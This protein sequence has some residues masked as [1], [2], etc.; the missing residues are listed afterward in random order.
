M[1]NSQQPLRVLFVCTGNICRSPM[2]EALFRNKVAKE[3]LSGRI[4]VDSAG[5]GG[6][7]IGEEPH[8]G[9]QQVLR[10]RGIAFD[11]IRARQLHP[12]DISEFDWILVMD[13]ENWDEVHQ[14]RPDARN[15]FKVLTF[16]SASDPNVPDPFY[17]GGFEHVYQLLNEALDN[18][19]HFLMERQN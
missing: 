1:P 8:Q 16:S 10:A 12:E 11:G 4:V 13:Q 9:T 14:L 2:A 7:H 3:G 6:W 15:V 18:F 19:L 17:S 5:T